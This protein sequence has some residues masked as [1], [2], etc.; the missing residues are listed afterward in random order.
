MLNSVTKQGIGRDT[1]TETH[2]GLLVQCHWCESQDGR[3]WQ[4]QCRFHWERRRNGAMY[5]SGS[6]SCKKNAA[7]CQRLV[8][9][10]LLSLL[11]G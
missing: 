6:C 9:Q 8:P 10:W 7:E 2:E 3:S 4:L 1:C 11:A 5:T